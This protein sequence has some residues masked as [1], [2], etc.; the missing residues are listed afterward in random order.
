M[1]VSGLAT[2]VIGVA[3]TCTRGPATTPTRVSSFGEFLEIFGGRDYGVTGDPVRSEVWRALVA[4]SFGPLVIS[5]VVAATGSA[6]A[7]RDFSDGVPTAIINIAATSPGAWGNGITATIA[8]ASDGNA[9]HFNLAVSWN[10][11]TQTYKNL[12]TTAGNNNLLAVIGAFDSNPSNLVVVTKI[13][14]GRPV[15]ITDQ[16]LDDTAGADGTLA[17][18]DFT[19]TDGPLDT[20]A[21]HRDS[22]TGLPLKAVFVAGRST[23]AVKSTLNTLAAASNDRVFLACPDNETTSKTA[24]ITEVQGFTR[25]DR[26]VYCFNHTRILDPET[27]E[28]MWVEPH[29]WLASILSQRDDD[30]HPGDADNAAFLAA[31]TELAHPALTVGD[32]DSF[33]EQGIAALERTPDGVVFVDAPSTAQEQLADGQPVSLEVWNGWSLRTRRIVRDAFGLLNDAPR[34]ELDDFLATAFPEDNAENADAEIA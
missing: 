31:V 25:D 1:A 14:D 21:N 17:D 28:L 3:G 12:D 6:T 4:K 5:R 7:E 34:E 23:S 10:G 32:Y 18:S 2:N 19:A 13:A 9:N 29:G 26:L 33:T 20:L 30:V 15:N 24:A 27:A 8:D 22:V 11:T 16:A